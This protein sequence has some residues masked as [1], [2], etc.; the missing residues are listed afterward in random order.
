MTIW[1]APSSATSATAML[2]ASWDCSH[3]SPERKRG[4]FSNH[5]APGGLLARRPG[6]GVGS[7]GRSADGPIAG[8]QRDVGATP[9]GLHAAGKLDDDSQRNQ[10]DQGREQAVLRQIL[11]TV[12][13]LQG[14]H[15]AP[16]HR[17]T[18][19]DFSVGPEVAV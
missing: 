10:C 9:H 19:P 6:G 15:E 7:A 14:L 16:E 13:R 1:S 17:L 4:V 18:K 3:Q 8:R 5:E 2:T 12:L 11:P